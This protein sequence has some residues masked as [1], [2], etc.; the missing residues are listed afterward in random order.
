MHTSEV[1]V[2]EAVWVFPHFSDIVDC[3]LLLP[4]NTTALPHAAA[5]I[6]AKKNRVKARFWTISRPL[7]DH[8][9]VIFGSP[10]EH[11]GVILASFWEHFQVILKTFW[12][13][14]DH[15]FGPLR[16]HFF[17]VLLQPNN[18]LSVILFS[19]GGSMQN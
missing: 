5:Q 16:C 1:A 11:F 2:A 12:G 15:S 8:F 3:V 4:K 10:C 17:E 6:C 7:S 9:W 18:H 14:F 13:P 19:I